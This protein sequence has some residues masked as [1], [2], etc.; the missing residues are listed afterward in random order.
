MYVSILNVQEIKT[1]TFTTPETN[2]FTIIINLYEIYYYE[3]HINFM[4][5]FRLPSPMNCS[6]KKSEPVFI[7]KLISK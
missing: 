7:F 2:I 1:I 5:I 3:N 4:S 6:I